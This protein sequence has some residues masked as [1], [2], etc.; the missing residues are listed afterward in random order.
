MIFPGGTE[1]RRAKTNTFPD[2]LVESVEKKNIVSPKL[3]NI[4]AV[5]VT[6]CLMVH[7]NSII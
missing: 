2:M 5:D 7:N 3:Y 6:F 1:R 4:I